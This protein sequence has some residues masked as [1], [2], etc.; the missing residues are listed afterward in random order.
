MIEIIENQNRLIGKADAIK[1]LAEK[2]EA[3]IIIISDSHGN[4]LVFKNIVR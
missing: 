2:E 3:R 1:E 4:P